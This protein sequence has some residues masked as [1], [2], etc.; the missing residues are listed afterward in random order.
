MN[1]Q[2]FDRD[3]IGYY[4][5]NEY[6][7]SFTTNSSQGTSLVLDSGE[8]ITTRDGL[9]KSWDSE[10]EAKVA[11]NL[12]KRIPSNHEKFGEW[13]TIKKQQMTGSV[14]PSDGRGQM[15]DNQPHRTVNPAR[16]ETEPPSAKVGRRGVEITNQEGADALQNP[17]QHAKTAKK[18]EAKSRAKLDAPITYKGQSFTSTKALEKFIQQDQA[19]GQSE[20]SKE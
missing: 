17:D 6:Y 10:L 14:R 4:N 1:K 9:L 18:T 11:A 3:F 16:R 8:P 7:V 12:I 2:Q 5:P 13:D 20:S 15:V 19:K